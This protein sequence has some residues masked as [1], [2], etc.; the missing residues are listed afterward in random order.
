MS[1][2]FF[3]VILRG[4]VSVQ[5]SQVLNILKDEVT[6]MLLVFM[7]NEIESR[8]PSSVCGLFQDP[9]PSL[10]IPSPSLG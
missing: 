8:S 9:E 5:N 1:V 4:Q 6:H 7:V 2:V 3:N 10:G